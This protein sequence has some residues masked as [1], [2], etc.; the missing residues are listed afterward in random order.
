MKFQQLRFD[1]LKRQTDFAEKPQSGP[2]KIKIKNLKNSTVYEATMKE[3]EKREKLKAERYE[4]G[5]LS[6]SSFDSSDA[7]LKNISDKGS[8][9][10]LLNCLEIE[11]NLTGM[12]CF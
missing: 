12:S 5:E 8:S 11:L 9:F 10:V 3:I 1:F 6:S 2:K 4:E 7:D